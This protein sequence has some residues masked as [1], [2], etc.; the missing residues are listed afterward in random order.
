MRRAVGKSR[1][2][3]RDPLQRGTVNQFA[4]DWLTQATSGVEYLER[5]A[6]LPSVHGPVWRAKMVAYY[7]PRVVA[8][9]ASAPPGCEKAAHTL[10]RRIRA[11]TF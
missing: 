7:V 11:L 5:L 1:G 6:S 2:R 9:I 8:L 10:N 3:S 4:G